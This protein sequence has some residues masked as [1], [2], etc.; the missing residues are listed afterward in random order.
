VRRTS[1]K[2]HIAMEMVLFNIGMMPT[3]LTYTTV[4]ALKGLAST[5]NSLHKALES[6]ELRMRLP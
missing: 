5:V 6:K 3:T 4:P 1:V 2:A